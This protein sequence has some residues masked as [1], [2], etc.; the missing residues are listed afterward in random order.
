M[1]SVGE[2]QVVFS[3]KEKPR[4]DQPLVRDQTKI[5]MTN[6]LSLSLEEI[7][8]R[9]DLRW[10]IELFFKELKSTLGF[11]HYRFR[12]FEAVE[13]WVE[14]CLITFLYLEQRRVKQLAS[15]RISPEAKRW[16]SHQRTHGLRQAVCQQAEAK[17]AHTLANWSRTRSGLRK[18]KALVRKTR[19]L[20]YR[21]PA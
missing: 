8:E 14:C 18:L 4:N 12:R 7:I 6:D 3:V 9:Y 21:I 20:E 10:Q 5:L 16:W 1:H 11:G 15:R 17:G 2:V 19:P 13:S